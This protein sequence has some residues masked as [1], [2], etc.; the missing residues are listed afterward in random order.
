MYF[1]IILIL[2]IL[3]KK[4]GCLLAFIFL[5]AALTGRSPGFP[6]TAGLPIPP[7]RTVTWLSSS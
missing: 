5:F 7:G 4:Y 1:Q 3:D 2:K 6:D